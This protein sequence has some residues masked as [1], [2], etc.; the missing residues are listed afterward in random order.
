MKLTHKTC[1]NCGKWRDSYIQLGDVLAAICNVD[2]AVT[3]G[4]DKCSKWS[5]IKF[6]SFYNPM[7]DEISDIR[8]YS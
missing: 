3:K 4:S 6:K 8:D 1:S 2:A 5:R 7:K